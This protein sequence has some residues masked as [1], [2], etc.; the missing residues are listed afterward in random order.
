MLS[1][2][3]LNCA[4][5]NRGE[6]YYFKVSIL[7]RVGRGRVVPPDKG[8]NTKRDLKEIVLDS[9]DYKEATRLS[10]VRSSR[11]TTIQPQASLESGL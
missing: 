4:Y 8:G 11:D 3:N 2:V 5:S 10:P 9:K 7:A 1:I 6:G